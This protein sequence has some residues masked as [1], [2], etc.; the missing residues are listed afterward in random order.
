VSVI[1]GHS[2]P[3]T[4]ELANDSATQLYCGVCRE[5]YSTCELAFCHLGWICVRCS[6][7]LLEFGEF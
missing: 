5:G 4:K 6:L 3:L 1:P 7:E 2:V